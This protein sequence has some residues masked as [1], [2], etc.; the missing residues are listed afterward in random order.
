MG[1][2]K[3]E[4]R[5]ALDRKQRKLKQWGMGEGATITHKARMK[6]IVERLKQKWTEW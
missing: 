2:I 3:L 4:G 1:Y 6:L 5:K